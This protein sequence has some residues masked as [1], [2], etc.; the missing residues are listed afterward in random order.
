MCQRLLKSRWWSIERGSSFNVSFKSRLCKC[1][2]HKIKWPELELHLELN[3][4][5]E[6]RRQI[7]QS[8]Y[9]VATCVQP[10][11][12]RALDWMSFMTPANRMFV[13]TGQLK[14]DSG[15]QTRIVRASDPGWVYH[16]SAHLIAWTLGKHK[17]TCAAAVFSGHSLLLSAWQIR[18]VSI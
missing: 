10:E 7:G 6:D 1:F 2:I 15:E 16:L 14:P 18:A 11:C 4:E 3:S 13:T 8:E 9:C 5:V 12:D 17:H